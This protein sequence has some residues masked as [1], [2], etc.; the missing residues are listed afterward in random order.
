MS[1]PGRER[2]PREGA[3]SNPTL[4]TKVKNE[5]SPKTEVEVRVEAAEALAAYAAIDQV[6]PKDACVGIAGL[7]GKARVWL[8]AVPA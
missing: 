1:P 7:L 6:D 5:V 8:K 3:I 4:T 2:R